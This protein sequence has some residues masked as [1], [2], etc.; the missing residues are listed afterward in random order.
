MGSYPSPCIC[1]IRDSTRSPPS[2]SPTN[3]HFFF[4]NDTAPTEIY[5]LSLHD[6]LPICG[7]LN[8]NHYLAVAIGYLYTNR[9]GWCRGDRKSTRLNS[10][11]YSI[12]YAGFCLKKNATI[13]MLISAC[14]IFF[15][16]QRL[17]TSQC[18]AVGGISLRISGATRSSCRTASAVRFLRDAATT[19]ISAFPLPAPLRF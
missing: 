14:R 9:P 12:S 4:F 1:S 13:R 16:P 6:A 7:L 17:P 11:H 8:P 18:C 5:T 3:E 15:L 19:K 10:S 2:Y